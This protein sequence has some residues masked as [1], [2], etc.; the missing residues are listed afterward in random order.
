VPVSLS[1]VDE[2]KV[3]TSGV[4]EDE[5]GSEDSTATSITVPEDDISLEQE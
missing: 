1:L 4:T 3:N 2:E 5:V